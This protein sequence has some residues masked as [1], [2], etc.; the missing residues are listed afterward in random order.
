MKA[1]KKPTLGQIKQRIRDMRTPDQKRKNE[2]GSVSTH[3]MSY[4]GSDEEGYYVY[5]TIF[6]NEDGSWTDYL[7]EGES[8]ENW[9]KTY[10]EAKKRNEVIAVPS[11]YIA[12]DLAGGSW[13]P[14]VK[15]K[16]KPIPRII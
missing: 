2:D 8:D 5:P 6:P 14:Q 7:S 3:K 15:I 12:E 13:K 16:K 1:K 11:K 4:E 9:E 10:Q